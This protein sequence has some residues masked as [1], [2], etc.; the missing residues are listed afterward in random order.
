M[1]KENNS[2]IDYL[3][4]IEFLKFGMAMENKKQQVITEIFE[5]CKKNKNFVFHNNLVKEVS[6][7]YNFGNPFDAT[8]LD[9][10]DKFPQ[11]LIEN[12]YFI[13]HQ[14]R[15]YHKFVKGN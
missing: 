9:N 11:I 3:N 8:K 10:L 5:I 13:I 12:D 1:R 14:G 4:W 7:K 15:G 2:G 6:K